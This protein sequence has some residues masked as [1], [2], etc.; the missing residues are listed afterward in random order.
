MFI[1]LLLGSGIWILL[2]K[3]LLINVLVIGDLFEILLLNVFDLVE[4]MIW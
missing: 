4:L 2:F 1:L 3:F